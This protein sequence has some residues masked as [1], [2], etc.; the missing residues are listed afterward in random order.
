MGLFKAK[1]YSNTFITESITTPGTVK[2]VKS[3]KRLSN[4]S[5]NNK[6]LF[7]YFL[8]LKSPIK[9]INLLLLGSSF[10]G[11][12][13]LFRG[14]LF[15]RLL[16]GLL[17]RLLSSLLYWRLSFL[18]SRLLS[19]LGSWLLN[20]FGLFDLDR[21]NLLDLLGFLNLSNLEFTSSLASLLS[22]ENGSIS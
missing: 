12:N 22:L 16:D 10:L 2:I 21:L 4:C 11:S 15:S 9:K 7:E 20:L 8:A 17:C 6:S 14:S 1:K 5:V 18:G 13:L 3:F 19:F